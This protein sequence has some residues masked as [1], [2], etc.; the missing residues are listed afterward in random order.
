MPRRRPRTLNGPLSTC[1]IFLH[2]MQESDIRLLNQLIART[3]VAETGVS[4]YPQ[5]VGTRRNETIKAWVHN[6]AEKER[7]AT[8]SVILQDDLPGEQMQQ[9]GKY[10]I[11]LSQFVKD[12]E[13]NELRLVF[14][15]TKQEAVIRTLRSLKVRFTQEH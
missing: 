15:R 1:D 12:F 2:D 11:L 5:M 6:V 8:I 13:G 10:G 9:I 14:D 3:I 7:Q 4:P